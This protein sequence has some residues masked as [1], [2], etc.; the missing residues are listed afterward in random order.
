MAKLV[1]ESRMA[2]SA[3]SVFEWHARPGALERLSP[4]W[5]RFDVMERVGG[6][7]AGARVVLRTRVGPAT[8]RWVLVHSDF[9]AGRQF[10]DVQ[11]RGPFAR[12]EHLHRMEP[13]GDGCV[14][15]DE[16]DFTL[17]GGVIGRWLG[18]RVLCDR[19]RRVFSY[20][21][22]I[23]AQDLALHAAA[24]ERGVVP[25]NVLV[26]GASGLVGSALL[27]LLTT[28]GHRVTRLVRTSSD[29][30]DAVPYDPLTGK[31]DESRLR[32]TDAVVHL[33][34]ENIAGRRWSKAQKERIRESRVRGT[35]ALAEAVAGME[36]PPAVFVC[37]SAVGCYGDRRDEVLHEDS[38]V[39]AGFLADVCR[40]WEQAA[41]VAVE[42]GVR[43][44]WL[45]FG[46]ILSPRGGALRRM[47]LP[48]RLGMGGR[49][50]SGRQF[51]SWVSIEDAIGAVHHALVDP[52][53][54]GAVNVVAP[55]AVTNREFTRTLGRVLKRPTLLPAPA[56]ALR[57]ALGEM[58]DAL[59]LSS[60]RV[61]PRVLLRTGYVFREPRLEGAL[62]ALL[63]R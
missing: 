46:V 14:L 8:L 27:P 17:P 41:R 49:L 24:R 2:A 42:R 50:G 40:E 32:G 35:R 15:R 22:R 31:V 18:E 33:A 57:L 21:H 6:I 60:A 34:G 11:V 52:A 28:G 43:V 56:P 20:R 54:R 48:F 36:T 3:P 39:G 63:G 7:E 53:V 38:Q 59:L 23:T 9:V 5:E 29:Q 45:R 19:L 30:G 61:E 12:W 13:D 62:R 26:S 1:F 51:M 47:L 58:S 44:V 37:A 4:P 25:L 16:L 55:E 10:R